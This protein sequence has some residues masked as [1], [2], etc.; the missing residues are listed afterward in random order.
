MTATG[1][2]RALVVDDS[3]FFA[4]MTAATLTEEHDIEATHQTSAEDAL[5]WLEDTDVD[6]IVSD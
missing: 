1:P 6:C 5:E 4:E 3:E 2:I